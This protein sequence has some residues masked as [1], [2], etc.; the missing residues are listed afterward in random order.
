MAKESEEINRSF[1]M[2]LSDLLGRNRKNSQFVHRKNWHLFTND[3][4]FQVLYNDIMHY[5][6]V[7]SGKV[8]T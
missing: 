1:L 5:S 4:A 6:F 2:S 7:F 8:A 3:Y